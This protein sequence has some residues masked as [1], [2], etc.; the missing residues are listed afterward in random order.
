MNAIEEV[1]KFIQEQNELDTLKFITCGS[2]DDGKSTLLGRIL[3]EAQLIFDDQVDALVSDSK[4]IGTQGE[5]IDFALLVDG[6]A[7]EREQGIT[8][9]VAYRFFSTKNRKF[10]VADSPGHEQFTRNMVT[11]A[12]N[13]DLAIILIDGRKGVLEQTKRHSFIAD[14][15]GIK[16]I[17]V[18]VNKMDLVNYSKEEFDDIC[19]SYSEEVADRLNFEKIS[20]VPISAL[21]GDNIISNSANM[22]W[23]KNAPLLELLENE[24]IVLKSN[25]NFSMPIQTVLRPN[26]DF[27][28][29]CG[30]VSS[31]TLKVGDSI[32]VSSSNEIAKVTDILIGD[33][34]LK[35]CYK[36]DS[37]TI[38]LDREIDI[39]RG[40]VLISKNFDLK[41]G[42]LFNSNIIWF[43]QDNC[44]QN[45]Y[46]NLKVGSKLINAKIIKIKNKIN[47]N[48]FEKVAPKNI[49]MN[50]IF[51]CE[52]LVDDPLSFTSYNEINA[53]GSFI[54]I[55]KTTNLT[56][57]G[58]IIN[59]G[60]RRDE[61][62]QWE[63]TEIDLQARRN[64][65]GTHS[66]VLWFTGLSGSGKS[67]IANLLEKKL[68]SLG[69]L[70]Y[71][72]DGDNLRHGL[73]HDLGFTKKDR[74]ENLRRSG[75]VSRLL[76]DAGITVIASF[77][78]PLR[79]DRDLIRSKFPVKDFIEIFV[80]VDLE[81]AKKRDPKGLYKKA[82]NNKI[83]NF[84]G[85]NSPYEEPKDPNL[86]IDTTKMSPDEA[87]ELIIKYLD[88]L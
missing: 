88:D 15:V 14:M 9:D 67:T 61:N 51:E 60:L 45:R 73:N 40:D 5:N 78:S 65:T 80:K 39:S 77:I 56:V 84:T 24:K 18:A 42:K 25:E 22:S 23:Y 86:V 58:G 62:V 37:A 17:I 1:K 12:S 47:I 53:L 36:N 30:K 72:L 83:P 75:E 66:R 10:I 34:K 79:K 48:S 57:A 59:H 68:Y 43:S 74:I 81:T 71:I 46:F 70:T 63:N 55:D 28:G 50:D 2:V 41:S 54:L 82:L 32:K 16:N 20:F 44:H 19:F 33:Q 49:A 35:T 8:I 52:I 27:R 29:F 64:L 38:V 6:L 7:A 31:G 76:Y 13:A 4:K 21:L 85:I 11:A 69:R 3:Y 87:V 26:L